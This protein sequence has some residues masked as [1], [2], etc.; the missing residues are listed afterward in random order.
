MIQKGEHMKRWMWMILCITFLSGCGEK[1]TQEQTP[2]PEGVAGV[3]W[4]QDDDGRDYRLFL[5]EDG[6][7]SYYSP[8]AGNPYHDYD[9]CKSYT[10]NAESHEF[11]FDTNSCK[12]K[13][14]DITEDG[15]TL[16][17]LVDGDKI[18]FHREGSNK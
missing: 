6:T 4:L 17:L 14:V 11:S 13:F 18:V 9:L 12:M 5:G 8:T 16:L 7:V 15:K 10:Y 3:K 2:L 1:E